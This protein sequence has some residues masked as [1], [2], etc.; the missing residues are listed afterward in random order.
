MFGRA[1]KPALA[2]QG[3]LPNGLKKRGPNKEHWVTGAIFI[4]RHRSQKKL[5]SNGSS[6]TPL[7]CPSLVPRGVILLNDLMKK[8]HYSWR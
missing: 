1:P 5:A 6:L 4:E 8:K 7:S 2:P 3:A